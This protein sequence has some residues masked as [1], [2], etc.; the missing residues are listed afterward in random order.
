MSVTIEFEPKSELVSEVT[1]LDIV[2][3]KCKLVSINNPLRAISVPIGVSTH[4]LEFE[5]NNYSIDEVTFLDITNNKCKLVS[6]DN[7]LPILL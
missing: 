1:F 3:N 7:P 5:S 2:D 6:I 4:L